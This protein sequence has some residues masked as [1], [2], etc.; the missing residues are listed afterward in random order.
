MVL[1][2]LTERQKNPPLQAGLLHTARTEIVTLDTH[3]ARGVRHSVPCRT[4]AS[5]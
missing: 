4:G 3:Q 5:Q 2:T 1:G